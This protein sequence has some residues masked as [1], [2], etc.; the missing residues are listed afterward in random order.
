MR[1]DRVARQ[2]MT[3]PARRAAGPATRPP[4][5]CDT[6][7]G[8]CDM[9]RH[10][11]LGGHDTTAAG[12]DTTMRA[13]VWARLCA[14]GHPCAHLGAPVR[15]WAPL[16]APG[17]ACAHLGAPV[18]TWVCY[19]ASRLCTWCTQPV[20]VLSTVTESLFGHCS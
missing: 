12:H 20:F 9:A 14:P 5:S 16:C 6:A 3:W 17:R 19:W 4:A 18:C 2:A 13:R 1:L 15:T 11:R 8:A 10:G 7:L